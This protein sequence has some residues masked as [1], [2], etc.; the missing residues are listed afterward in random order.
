VELG[1]QRIL[2]SGAAE[3]ALAGA[4]AL[5]ASVARA[6]G[7]LSIMAGGGVNAGNAAAVVAASGVR[8]VHAACRGA[9]VHHAPAQAIGMALGARQETREDLVSA[10]VAT[11]A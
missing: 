5:A 8:E 10:I 1:F 7:R 6:A 3:T 9:A 2:T 4:A 11:L